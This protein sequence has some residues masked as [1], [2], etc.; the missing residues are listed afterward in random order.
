MGINFLALKDLF[1]IAEKRKDTNYD[2]RIQMVVICNKEIQDLLAEVPAPDG[3]SSLP[4]VAFHS[5]KSNVDA[6]S[7]V[8]S[9]QRKYSCLNTSKIN[10]LSSPFH[11]SVETEDSSCADN[12]FETCTISKRYWYGLH[13]I[14][15][16][17]FLHLL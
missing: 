7:L 8:N 17:I 4:D 2:V 13:C 6:I 15:L 9:G 14:A 12:V 10:N 1:Q 5:V 16:K 11:R 3:E